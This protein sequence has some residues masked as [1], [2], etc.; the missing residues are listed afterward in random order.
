MSLTKTKLVFWSFT[1]SVFLWNVSVFAQTENSSSE[2]SIYEAKHLKIFGL[3]VKPVNSEQNFTFYDSYSKGYESLVPEK[4]YQELKKQMQ[5]KETMF[6]LWDRVLTKYPQDIAEFSSLDAR[7]MKQGVKDF[8]PEF[9][10]LD[11]KYTNKQNAKA[12]KAYKA[13]YKELKP[14]DFAEK[15]LREMFM[16]VSSRTDLS[17]F[18]KRELYKAALAELPQGASKQYL[19]NRLLLNLI[20]AT[21]YGGVDEFGTVISIED[22]KNLMQ[23]LREQKIDLKT[24]SIA[25]N[26]ACSQAKRV[27]NI[28][29]AFCGFSGV[30]F[31]EKKFVDSLSF[32]K[33]DLGFDLN[34]KDCQLESQS[35]GSSKKISP[36]EMIQFAA[37]EIGELRESKEDPEVLAFDEKGNIQKYSLEYTEEE[38]ANNQAEVEKYF[39]RDLTCSPEVVNEKIAR[40]KA[41]LKSSSLA[42]RKRSLIE[43]DANDKFRVQYKESEATYVDLEIKTLYKSDEAPCENPDIKELVNQILVQTS[44]FKGKARKF[45]EFKANVSYGKKSADFKCNYGL[46]V[47]G[48]LNGMRTKHM[49]KIYIQPTGSAAN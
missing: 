35:G 34:S 13:E 25:N 28:L 16:N 1:F 14:L 22:V 48:K 46:L 43:E 19:M 33:E 32:L 3:N 41:A 38:R 36:L 26:V 8:Q 5:D 10:E 9:K 45:K 7:L 17:D 30:G 39:G 15:A 27:G 37:D 20:E 21:E 47:D 42:K 49:E 23:V 44:A 24:Q 4:S 40:L 6:K 11:G 31:Y 12:E 29:S 2:P 18:D